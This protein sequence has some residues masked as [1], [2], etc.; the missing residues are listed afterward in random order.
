MI[1]PSKRMKIQLNEDSAEATEHQKPLY[2]RPN[3]SSNVESRYSPYQ[4][5]PRPSSVYNSGN[6]V[7]RL[8][9]PLEADDRYRSPIESDNCGPWRQPEKYNRV[10]RLRD[11]E[12]LNIR[13]QSHSEKP[14]DWSL[15]K[16]HDDYERHH[17]DSEQRRDWYGHRDT[18]MYEGGGQSDQSKT[19]SNWQVESRS[20]PAEWL[21]QRREPSSKQSS[22]RQVSSL[23]PL[24]QVYSPDTSQDDQDNNR[25]QNASSLWE[26]RPQAR[27]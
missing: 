21:S 13:D 15:W 18:P 11:V 8:A 24:A 19:W 1:R 23:P 22:P 20:K 14:R 26:Y 4:Y 9:S 27:T 7:R 2:N 25:S 16:K 17:R 6:P 5:S 10:D 12:D 3:A